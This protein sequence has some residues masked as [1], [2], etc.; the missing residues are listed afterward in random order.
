MLELKG[1]FSPVVVIPVAVLNEIA[2]QMQVTIGCKG[3]IDYRWLKFVDVW[4]TAEYQ[5]LYSWLAYREKQLFYNYIFILLLK[6]LSRTIHTV[7]T[8][9]IG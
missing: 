9:L 4:I 7:E 3:I 2:I 5:L 8:L 1:C 6:H